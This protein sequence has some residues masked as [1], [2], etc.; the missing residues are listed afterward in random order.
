M[1][2]RRFLEALVVFFAVLGVVALVFAFT[3]TCVLIK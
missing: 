3:G 2:W 1:L